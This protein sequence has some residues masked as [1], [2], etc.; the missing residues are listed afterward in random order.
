MKGQSDLLSHA[1]TVGMGLA[2]II[3][4]V[5]AMKGITDDN[6]EFVGTNEI[7]QVCSIMKSAFEKI[8]PG[9]QYLSP[10]NTTAGRITVQLP[11]RIA[12]L[13]YRT[14]ITGDDIVIE[15]G[16]DIFVNETCKIGLNVSYAGSTGGGRTLL[17][18]IRYSNGTKEVR[19]SN[20]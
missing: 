17:E 11:E 20:A 2:L 13:R 12:D 7:T 18:L 5:A 1:I 19:I 16:G 3:A 9:Q 4:V 8:L 6:R 14:R 10:T 15:T